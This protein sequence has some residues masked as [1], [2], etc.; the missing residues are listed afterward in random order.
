MTDKVVD[1]SAIA[2][3]LFLEPGYQSVEKLLEG[4]DLFAPVLISFELA[5]TCAKKIRTRPDERDSLLS[6]FGMLDSFGIREIDVEFS[7]IIQMAESA[8]LSTYDASY[9]WLAKHLGCEL[10]TLDE[11]LAKAAKKLR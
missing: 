6:A 1:A 4:A 10:I 5:N 7:P 8:R 9:L 3:I 2:S 11:R